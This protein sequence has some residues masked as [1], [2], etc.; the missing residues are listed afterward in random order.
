MPGPVMR[1]FILGADIVLKRL[2]NVGFRRTEDRTNLGSCRYI[3]LRN[4][5]KA[6]STYMKATYM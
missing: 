3:V 1:T 5:I 6:S 2:R 4:T